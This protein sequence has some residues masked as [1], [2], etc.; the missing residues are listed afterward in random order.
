[1]PVLVILAL[2]STSVAFAAPAAPARRHRPRLAVLVVVDQ[3]SSE[4]FRRIRPRLVAG[5]FARFV[6]AGAFYADARYR[7]A[8]TATAP[9]H[10]VLATGAYPRDSPPR[11]STF[12]CHPGFAWWRSTPRGVQH[13]PPQSDI[14]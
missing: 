7:H 1:M 13:E 4:A 2:L 14:L 3:F 6:D 5:G 10:A 11:R 9:G 12:P 8:D